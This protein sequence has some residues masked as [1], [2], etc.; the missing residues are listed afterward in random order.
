MCIQVCI[1]VYVYG[2]YTPYICVYVHMCL[3][4]YTY[5]MYTY[6]T[7]HTLYNTIYTYIVFITLQD[8]LCSALY[9]TLCSFV[10]TQLLITLPCKTSS[11]NQC[12]F[13]IIMSP[14]PDISSWFE[15]IVFYAIRLFI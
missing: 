11:K 5:M 15:L 8:L 12:N 7:L 1:C 13:N 9:F 4:I 3:Q 10:V 6:S 14:V 2:T